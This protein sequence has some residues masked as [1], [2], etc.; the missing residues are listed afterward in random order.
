MNNARIGLTEH[1]EVEFKPVPLTNLEELVK[2]TK[3][4]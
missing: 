3:Y 2:R 4:D 1:P